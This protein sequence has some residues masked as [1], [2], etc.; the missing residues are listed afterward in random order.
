MAVEHFLVTANVTLPRALQTEALE[1]DL[2]QRWGEGMG[3]G[4]GRR[5]RRAYA[6]SEGFTEGFRIGF[7]DPFLLGLL[8]W[9]RAFHLGLPAT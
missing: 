9:P 1:D 3:L 8:Q 2:S 6:W 7:T 5:A 4:K